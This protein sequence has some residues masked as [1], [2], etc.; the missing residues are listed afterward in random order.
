MS[1]LEQVEASSQDTSDWGVFGAKGGAT[2]HGLAANRLSTASPNFS[3]NTAVFNLYLSGAL[4]S[5]SLDN[6]YVITSASALVLAWGRDF[7]TTRGGA[8]SWNKAAA[9]YRVR[10]KA[11]P[12]LFQ[13]LDKLLDGGV[14]VPC[15]GKASA[16][17]AL[18]KP[19]QAPETPL[20][21][22]ERLSEGGIVLPAE[23]RSGPLAIALKA[24]EA[25]AEAE[26]KAEAEAEAEAEAGV[27]AQAEAEAEAAKESKRKARN[28]KQRAARAARKASK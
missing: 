18:A 6:G 15:F 26:A 12:V 19:E 4:D 20:A 5:V 1:I 10:R 21:G 16:Q 3:R 8:V 11:N 27:K 23:K 2:L 17:K 25:E 13:Q 7:R 9:A 24:A 28:A 22:S 14:T